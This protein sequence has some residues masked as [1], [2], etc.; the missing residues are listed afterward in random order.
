MIL[1]SRA[2]FFKVFVAVFSWLV[3]SS[4]I[5]APSSPEWGFFAHRRLNRL[6]VFTLDPDMMP[7]FRSNLEYL[8]DHAVDPD[9]RRYATRHEAVRHYIDIDHWGSYPFPDVPRNWTEALFW[10]A[11]VQIIDANQD[12]T[13]WLVDRID[14]ELDNPVV[15]L[16]SS[17]G[18]RHTIDLWSYRQF[19]NENILPQYYEDEWS[20]S[21]TQLRT[22]SWPLPGIVA[23][24][25][26]VDAETT[27]AETEE[28]ES[29]PTP[30]DNDNGATRDQNLNEDDRFFAGQVMSLPAEV[31]IKVIDHFSEY[32]ILPYHLLQ[33]QR[34][35]TLAF[36]DG[37]PGRVL[38]LAA[39]MGHYIG[40]ATVPLHTTENYNGQLTDQVGIHGFWESRI[41]EL[42]ADER[43]DFLVGK[44][45]YIDDQSDFFWDIVLSSHEL[46]DSVLSTEKRL[47]QTYPQDRQFCYEERLERTIRTQCSEYALAWNEAMDGMVEERFRTAIHAIG[48]CWY[49]AWV[50]AGQ[51]DLGGMGLSQDLAEADSLNRAFEQGEIRGRAHE[52]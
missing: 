11:E 51:P 36:K 42:I 31:Q 33:H 6:A 28:T 44:A 25:E 22:L 2:R 41:P 14:R 15:E 18:Q 46:V 32:G 30:S 47:S 12:T 4:S 49:T 40:D 38:Q 26:I 7:F 43:F 21:V 23:P 17:S 24:D 9:K 27:N 29:D 48:S 3:L 37:R 19:W 8:T 13:S 45:D 39:E 1:S 5:S 50:D 16:S 10:K 34:R 52:N 20:L 35:L